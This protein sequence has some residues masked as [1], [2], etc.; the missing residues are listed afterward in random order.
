L[1]KLNEISVQK[2]EQESQI[3]ELEV[4]KKKLEFDLKVKKKQYHKVL[5]R[6]KKIGKYSKSKCKCV[7]ICPHIVFS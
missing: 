5:Q 7:L 1:E 3:K 2:K 6:S 4:Q